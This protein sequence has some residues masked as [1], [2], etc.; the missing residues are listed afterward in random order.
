MLTCFGKRLRRALIVA[1]G[2]WAFAPLAASAQSGSPIILPARLDTLAG[3]FL[4]LDVAVNG[5][6]FT[7]ALDSGGSRVFR[8]DEEK[9][10]RAGLT[11]TGVG[12]SAGAG[13]TVDPDKR[14]HSARLTLAAMTPA[15]VALH[16]RT[17]V[18]SPLPPAAAWAGFDCVM[19]QALL[20]DYAI[21]LDYVTPRVT[22]FDPGTY[23]PSPRAQ[24][25]PFTLDRD[26]PY[27]DV[28][29]HFGEQDSTTVRM[30]LD[31]GASYYAALL[32]RDAL[33][34]HKVS[35]RIGR[36]A[37]RPEP[38]GNLSLTAARLTRVTVGGVAMEQPVVA[39]L[40]SSSAGLSGDGLVGAGFF[41]RFHVAF[42]YVKREMY[43]DPNARVAEPQTFDASGV[44][45]VRQDP[46]SPYVV[47]IVLPGSPTASAD[48]RKGDELVS[49]DGDDAG[50]LTQRELRARLSRAGETC[51]LRLR[52]GDRTHVV[53]VVLRPRL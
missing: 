29:L 5:T 25:I 24:V 49:I 10:L 47:D 2:M 27:A 15:G 4:L 1:I 30:M 42:N 26:N 32:T 43:L 39:L 53:T 7:C 36:T 8:V 38:V 22:L 12:L 44:G 33:T 28:T 6:P 3:D 19:G 23:R 40:S 9:A 21:E 17:V 45:F 51:I 14:L 18:I 11:P 41:R 34:A 50:P 46:A 52:R 48:L 31:T 20:R 16:D 37:E 13:P 35:S